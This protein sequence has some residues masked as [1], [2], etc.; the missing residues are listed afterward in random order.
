MYD[1]ASGDM[2]PV[3]GTDQAHLDAAL[4]RKQQGVVL[5]VHQMVDIKDKK[6]CVHSITRKTVVLDSWEG[7]PMV[8]KGEEVFIGKCRFVVQSAGREMIVLR[9]A[10]GTRFMGEDRYNKAV[11]AKEKAN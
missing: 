1:K 3:E 7:D 6:F 2:V 8:V 10:P 5:R 11:K 4:P 9:G